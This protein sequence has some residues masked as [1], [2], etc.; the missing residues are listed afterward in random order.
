M[1]KMVLNSISGVSS[2]ATD[3]FRTIVE[4][5]STIFK[6]QGFDPR[7]QILQEIGE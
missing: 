1:E 6:V 4:A 7:N 5:Q 2:S 3:I